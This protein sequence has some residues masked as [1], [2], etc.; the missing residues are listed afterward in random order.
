[1]IKTG[2][3]KEDIFRHYNYCYRQYNISQ[4]LRAKTKQG[5]KGVNHS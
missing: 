4:K 1:M 5:E 2:C 3:K